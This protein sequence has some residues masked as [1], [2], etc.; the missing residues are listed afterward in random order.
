MTS[1]LKACPFCGNEALDAVAS[2]R[3]YCQGCYAQ[4]KQEIHEG[5][6]VV[7]ARWNTRAPSPAVAR[8][9]EACR[10]LFDEDCNPPMPNT[11]RAVALYTDVAA[12]LAAVEKEIG[13]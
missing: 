12:A 4:V 5:H 10:N 7:V 13:Q 3:V 9:V 1:E 8:L 11:S 2:A 6:D